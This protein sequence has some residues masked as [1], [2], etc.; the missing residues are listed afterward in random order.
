MK[1][2]STAVLSMSRH[3]GL[4]WGPTDYEAAVVPREPT[5]LLGERHQT[6]H[7]SDGRSTTRSQPCRLFWAL[8]LAAFTG[9]GIPARE[10]GGR[11]AQFSY[12]DAGVTCWLYKPDAEP[13]GSLSCV[14]T[15]AAR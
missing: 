8:V 14:R 4:N 13:S 7:D 10:V 12:P 5:A 11:I 2:D 15:E 6:Q 3:P 9:C 1:S